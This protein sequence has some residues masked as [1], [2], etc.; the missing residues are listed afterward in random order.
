MCISLFILACFCV[1]GSRGVS[2][3]ALPG[4]WAARPSP[5]YVRTR[6]SK[7]N[8]GRPP[9]PPHAPF[10]AVRLDRSWLLPNPSRT[11]PGSKTSADTRHHIIISNVVA[12]CWGGSFVVVCPL[13]GFPWRSRSLFCCPLAHSSASVL[14]PTERRQRQIRWVFRRPVQGRRLARRPRLRGTSIDRLG[15]RVRGRFGQWLGGR[16]LGLK[17]G[18]P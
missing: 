13:S 10:V 12:A 14:T 6:V 17:A 15:H 7:A 1:F 11:R 3:R 2:V 18:R 9:T 5:F 4:P 8:N 16:R